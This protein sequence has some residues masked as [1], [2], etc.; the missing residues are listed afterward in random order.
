M[1]WWF[2]I[3]ELAAGAVVWAGLSAYIQVR[4]RLKKAENQPEHQAGTGHQP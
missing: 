4:E 1:I 2:L 3:V